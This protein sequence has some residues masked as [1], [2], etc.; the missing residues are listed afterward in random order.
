[1]F[2]QTSF[3]FAVDEVFVSSKNHI[4]ALVGI[5]IFSLA[6]SLVKPENKNF[7]NHSAGPKT[8]MNNVFLF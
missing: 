3:L 2:Y 8:K 6:D 7:T 4:L 1:V 5:L